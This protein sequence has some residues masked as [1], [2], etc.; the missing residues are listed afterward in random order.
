M[1]RASELL[2]NMAGEQISEDMIRTSCRACG[3]VQTLS[4]TIFD[5]TTD[6]MRPR[7]QCTEGCGPIL[8][9]GLAMDG[10][11]PPGRG[12]PATSSYLI[13]NPKELLVYP[14]HDIERRII[15]PA[16]PNALD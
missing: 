2:S 12:I 7:Y 3:T 4:E 16:S 11:W 15:F 6:P 14:G 9:I 1:P 13:R 10:T 8:I 5:V